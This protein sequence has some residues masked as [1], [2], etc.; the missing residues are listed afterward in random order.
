[1][2]ACVE[3]L[4]LTEFISIVLLATNIIEKMIKIATFN[5]VGSLTPLY[6]E[7]STIVESNTTMA[8]KIKMKISDFFLVRFKLMR[9]LIFLHL[10]K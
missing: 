3:I 7:K 6:E 4:F 9:L 5:Q 8:V 1:L 10:T 2:Y